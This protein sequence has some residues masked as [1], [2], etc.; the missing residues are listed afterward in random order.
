MFALGS[1]ALPMASSV[2]T[3][4]LWCQGI[5]WPWLKQLGTDNTML[6][7]CVCAVQD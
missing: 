4:Q 6:C 1:M 2:Y 3:T 7:A 5:L